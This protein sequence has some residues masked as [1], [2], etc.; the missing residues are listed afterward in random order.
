[1]TRLGAKCGEIFRA[2]NYNDNLSDLLQA[3]RN[4][5]GNFRLVPIN[6]AVTRALRKIPRAD[7]P[8]MPDRIIAATAW[9]LKLPL[10]TRDSKIRAA[11]LKT[12]W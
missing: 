8:D 6:L 9:H 1:M 3:L 10:V 7:V 12:I 4:K 2:R 5:T 11:Q